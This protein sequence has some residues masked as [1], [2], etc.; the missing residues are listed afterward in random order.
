MH[1]AVLCAWKVGIYEFQQVDV[2][3]SKGPKP[4][5]PSGF[6]AYWPTVRIE[7]LKRWGANKMDKSLGPSRPSRPS[8]HGAQ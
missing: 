6:A 2:K 1:K 5:V 8:R 7:T 4:Q 3:V